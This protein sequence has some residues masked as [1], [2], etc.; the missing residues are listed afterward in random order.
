MCFGRVRSCWGQLL[1]E[2]GAGWFRA[3][4]PPQQLLKTT[5]GIESAPMYV[6]VPATIRPGHHT[7]RLP[8][9]LI[10]SAVRLGWRPSNSRRRRTFPQCRFLRRSRIIVRRRSRQYATALVEIDATGKP[11]GITPVDASNGDFTLRKEIKDRIMHMP[12]TPAIAIADRCP[13]R[14]CCARVFCRS[15][16]SLHRGVRG[17]G[18]KNRPSQ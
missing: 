13:Q 16:C 12:I 11:V 10:R 15:T 4:F 18:V 14:T 17:C 5:H 6:T 2:T 9:R 3:P 8:A 1:L 7:V